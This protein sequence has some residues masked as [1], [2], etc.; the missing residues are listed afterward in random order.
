MERIKQAKIS[1]MVV[2]HAGFFWWIQHQIQTNHLNH[3]LGCG[4]K[5]ENQIQ[6]KW[7]LKTKFKR[8]KDCELTYNLRFLM[9]STTISFSG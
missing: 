9:N 7:N 5:F 8:V 2:Q 6:R 3:N 4:A 1:Q